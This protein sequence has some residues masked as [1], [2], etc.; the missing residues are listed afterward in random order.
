[1]NTHTPGPWRWELNEKSHLVTLCGGVPRFDM[2][3]MDFVRY[4]MGHGAP[5]FRSGPVDNMHRV[6][7]F[8]AIVLGREHH[9]GWF[10]GIEHPDAHLIAAAP[11][12]LAACKAAQQAMGAHGPC[13]NNSCSDCGKTWKLLRAAISKATGG[14]A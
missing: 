2:T 14:V 5:R 1:M 6:E 4:G 11:E 13:T 10:K 9:A 3:V 8:G 12:L 7:K